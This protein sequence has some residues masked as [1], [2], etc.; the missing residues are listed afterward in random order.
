MRIFMKTRNL[1]VQTDLVSKLLMAC[2]LHVNVCPELQTTDLQSER[3][4]IL[5]K[6]KIRFFCN[7][8]AN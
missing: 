4:N 7:D 2:A 1:I 3:K 8:L 5:F 6:S